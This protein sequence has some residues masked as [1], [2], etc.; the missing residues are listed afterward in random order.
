MKYAVKEHVENMSAAIDLDPTFV[1]KA[2]ETSK[3]RPASE[4]RGS[5]LADGEMQIRNS[6]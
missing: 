1:A 5:G 3:R 6:L 4:G 2:G